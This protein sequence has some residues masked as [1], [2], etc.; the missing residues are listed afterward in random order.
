MHISE[1]EFDA[2]HYYSS[3]SKDSTMCGA[4]ILYAFFTVVLKSLG[5]D[6]NSDIILNNYMPSK[7]KNNYYRTESC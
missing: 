7:L 1:H 4:Y 2:L 3:F 6:I 5:I